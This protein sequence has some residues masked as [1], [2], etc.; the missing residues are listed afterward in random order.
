MQHIEDNIEIA[1]IAITGNDRMTAV[2]TIQETME[3]IHE[4][5][6]VLS[7]RS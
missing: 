6:D 1:S 5:E 7:G 2:S 3:I 4:I